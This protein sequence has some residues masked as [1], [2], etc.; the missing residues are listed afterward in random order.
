MRF[1]PSRSRTISSGS[2]GERE[3]YTSVANFTDEEMEIH[4]SFEDVTAEASVF[5]AYTVFAELDPRLFQLWDQAGRA[6]DGIEVISDGIVQIVKPG[7]YMEGMRLMRSEILSV[8]VYTTPLKAWRKNQV[9]VLN[10]VQSDGKRHVGG[11]IMV[12]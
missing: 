11:Q 4:L 3:A 8:R 2:S 6:S 10:V 5:G 9:Y 7:A 12:F 1:W